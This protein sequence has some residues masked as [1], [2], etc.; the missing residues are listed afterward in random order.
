[1]DDETLKQTI[2][3]LGNGLLNMDLSGIDVA[4]VR[5]IFDWLETGV[6]LKYSV[7]NG[8][9]KLYVDKEW[10]KPYMDLIMTF[11]PLLDEKF[12]EIA[13]ADETGMMGMVFLLLGFEKFTDLQTIWADNTDKFELGLCSRTRQALLP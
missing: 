9:L 11:M 8:A 1:M 6:P 7:E 3:L 12:Q 13:A 2:V 10:Q 4:L 5:N